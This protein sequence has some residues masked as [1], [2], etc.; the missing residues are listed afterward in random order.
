M[1]VIL[2]NGPDA[3]VCLLAT[4]TYATCAPINANLQVSQRMATAVL[5]WRL[6]RQHILGCEEWYVCVHSDKTISNDL[7]D[8]SGL[9]LLVPTCQP[10][11]M[12]FELTNLKCKAAIV[13][14]PGKFLPKD[15][16]VPHSTSLLHVGAE[17]ITARRVVRNRSIASLTHH[18]CHGGGA[19]DSPDGL[20]ASAMAALSSLAGV[21]LLT[22]TTS[23]TQAGVFSLR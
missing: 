11:E 18:V 5:C 22:M 3:A 1:A 16:T 12:R 7:C 23:K 13:P 19:A 14:D 10:E 20:P 21:A 9:L 6:Y 8:L 17:P 2:P 15:M 4:C